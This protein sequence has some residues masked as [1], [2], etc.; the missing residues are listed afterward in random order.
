VAVQV[1]AVG[2]YRPPVLKFT[3]GSE[4]FQPP[5][6]TMT[7][8]VQTAVWACRPTG[9]FTREVGVQL[10][11]AGSS[12]PPVCR[13]GYPPHTIMTLPV[14]IAVWLVRGKGALAMEVGTHV[15]VSGS[16]RPPVPKP[17]GLYPPHTTIRLPVQT[18]V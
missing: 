10:S 13:S 6:T 12:L 17:R 14:Q 15:S 5:Q 8:P 4:P 18:A 7:L 9:A 11:I 2:S 1:S 3:P 16:Y